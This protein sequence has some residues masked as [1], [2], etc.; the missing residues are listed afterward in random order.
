VV[1]CETYARA[2]LA[3]LLDGND[4]PLTRPFLP[5]PAPTAAHRT[6]F[7]SS[8]PTTSSSSSS[9]R[10]L[11]VDRRSYE[12]RAAEA[13]ACRVQG[14][15]LCDGRSS[16]AECRVKLLCG[17]AERV[18]VIRFAVQPACVCTRYLLVLVLHDWM[19]NYTH[20]V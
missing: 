13:A 15:P 2:A 19:V 1:L 18:A 17:V 6:A 20:A 3:L 8:T 16:V 4:P 5:T 12:D 11:L 10:R 7:M 14:A 9:T